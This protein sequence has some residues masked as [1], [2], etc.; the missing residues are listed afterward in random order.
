ML[1]QVVDV[2][3]IWTIADEQQMDRLCCEKHKAIFRPFTNT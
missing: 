1:Y 3:V 2:S